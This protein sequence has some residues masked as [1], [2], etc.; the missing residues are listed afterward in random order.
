MARIQR[1]H[2]TLEEALAGV[3]AQ[4]LFVNKSMDPVINPRTGRL[5]AGTQLKGSP[6]NHASDQSNN[7][8][9]RSKF[10]H[11]QYCPELAKK[12]F[13][14]IQRNGRNGAAARRSTPKGI[15]TKEWRPI[16][17]KRLDLARLEVNK[18]ED[19]GLIILPDDI[20]DAAAAKEALAFNVAVMRS[21]E[22]TMRD[23]LTSA[24]MVL[25]FCKQK[26]ASK[27]ENKISL[28]E[29]FLSSLDD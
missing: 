2:R 27:V 28:A 15:R 19:Q 21:N 6:L 9:A 1:P 26:P 13:L 22:M 29:E 3:P 20:E 24:S 25:T 16:F 18:M 4:P 23:R 8:I 17:V 11:P 5:C 10:G 7:W 12:H 14:L